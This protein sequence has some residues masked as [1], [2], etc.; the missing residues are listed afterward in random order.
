MNEVI[1]RPGFSERKNL[2]FIVG[3]G[4][5]QND[6]DVKEFLLKQF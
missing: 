2:K 1:S 5:D 4:W 3:N 6:W